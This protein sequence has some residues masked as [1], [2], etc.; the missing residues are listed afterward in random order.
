[1]NVPHPLLA[2]SQK[3]EVVVEMNGV[4]APVKMKLCLAPPWLLSLI[5]LSLQYDTYIIKDD[6][7]ETSE[8]QEPSLAVCPCNCHTDPLFLASNQSSRFSISFPA[9]I[10]SNPLAGPT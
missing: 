8:S 6:T 5:S 9:S 7:A 10:I 3:L 1:M 2:R 4:L